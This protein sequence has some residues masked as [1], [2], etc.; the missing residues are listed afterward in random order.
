M[1]Q[2]QIKDLHS[3]ISKQTLKKNNSEEGRSEEDRKGEEER[4]RDELLYYL[5]YP[6]VHSFVKIIS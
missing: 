1:P 3:Q 2:L 4:E 5:A 6:M